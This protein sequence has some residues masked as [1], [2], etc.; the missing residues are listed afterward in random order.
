MTEENGTQANFYGRP[1]N[2]QKTK[3]LERFR[4]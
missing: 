3:N 2:N 4:A 1:K